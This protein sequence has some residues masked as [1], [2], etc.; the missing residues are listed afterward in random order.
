[1][2]ARVLVLIPHCRLG[3]N[4]TS[5]SRAGDSQEGLVGGFPAGK[6]KEGSSPPKG[7]MLKGKDEIDTLLPLAGDTI[8]KTKGIS[9]MTPP[10][11]VVAS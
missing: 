9:G 11:I 8:G 7:K 2:R 6:F 10:E 1:M 3:G 4:F 5:P